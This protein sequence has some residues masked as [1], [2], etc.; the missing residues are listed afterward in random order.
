MLKIK[1]ENFIF[2]IDTIQVNSPTESEVTKSNCGFLS[3]DPIKVKGGQWQYVLN[4]DKESGE[5]VVS[6]SDFINSYN[7]MTKALQLN[8]PRITRVDYRLDTK[9]YEY[10]DF[11]KLNA[12]L[13]CL[14][15]LTFGGAYKNRYNNSDILVPLEKAVKFTTQY[16][17][18]EFYNKAI[19]E[20][21]GDVKSRLEMR[22]LKPFNDRHID[23]SKGFDVIVNKFNEAIK[24][25]Y[26]KQL[27]YEANYGLYSH[28]WQIERR[29]KCSVNQF[30]FKYQEYLFTQ[31]QIKELLVKYFGCYDYSEEKKQA[32]T[33]RVERL[34]GKY[35]AYSRKD[36]EKYI[37]IFI[38]SGKAYF[39][40]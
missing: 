39:K 19:Q 36:I 14:V 18:G 2:G 34:C 32:L 33:R 15:S 16:Y 28:F 31:Q 1:K 21:Q 40:N 7:R 20:P 24:P 10:S 13:L 4:P 25:E 17:A 27:E 35:E 38:N 22:L 29:C 11:R 12:L 9:L 5:T 37:N 6:Y 26:F 3:K 30:L 23:P 8:N